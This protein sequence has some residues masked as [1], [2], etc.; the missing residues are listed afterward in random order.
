MRTHGTT[1]G[2]LSDILL[3]KGVI[4]EEQ[5]TMLHVKSEAQRAIEAVLD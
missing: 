5:A 4:S 1:V 2:E 3:K